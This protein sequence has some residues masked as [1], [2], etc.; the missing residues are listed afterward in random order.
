MNT[1]DYKNYNWLTSKALDSSRKI[2]HGLLPPV[3]EKF[4]LHAG[5]EELCLEF[6]SS[7]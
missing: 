2:A 6:S 1:W 7:S 5:I 4:G 3:L